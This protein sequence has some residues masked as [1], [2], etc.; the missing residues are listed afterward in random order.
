MG[1][2]KLKGLLDRPPSTEDQAKASEKFKEK[3]RLVGNVKNIT[4]A[5]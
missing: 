1:E 3:E 4:G 5:K 2:N